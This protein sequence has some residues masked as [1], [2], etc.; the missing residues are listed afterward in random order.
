MRSFLG[1]S[2][3]L[4]LAGVLSTAAIAD[5]KLKAELP[6]G[7]LPAGADGKPLNLDFETGTLRD[8]TA[9]G[10]AFA[11]QPVKGDTVFERRSDMR[12]EHAGQFWIGT[13]ERNQDAPQG[14]LT[15]APF[16]V[17]HRFAA[18]LVGGGPT[19]DTRV[20]LVQPGKVS[21]GCC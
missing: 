5:E 17:T 8:W 9:T 15:S 2:F 18:F 4:F 11:G 6:Q 20:E 13:Y 19:D 14:T 7:V 3:G 16:K 21:G 1:I 10:E 12:S